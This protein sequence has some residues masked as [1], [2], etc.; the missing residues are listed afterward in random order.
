MP[1]SIAL[2]PVPSQTINCTLNGQA[3]TLNVRQ[4]STGLYIDVLVANTPIIQG[5]ICQ[6]ANTIV[7]DVYLGFIGDLAFFDTQG[8]TDP[9]STGLGSRYILTYWM[10][11]ELPAGVF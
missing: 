7:R 1:M 10:P 9:V 6:N 5:V 11:S 2:Q 3:T 4:N 8:D